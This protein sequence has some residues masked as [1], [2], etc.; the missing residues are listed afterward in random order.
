MNNSKSYMD[1]LRLLKTAVTIIGLTMMVVLAVVI[2]AQSNLRWNTSDLTYAFENG[3]EDIE[4]DGEQQGVSE[5][6][7]M[8][9]R[10][11]DLT[12]TQI[13]DIV[14]ADIVIKWD[15][16]DHEGKEL[17]GSGLAH[18]IFSQDRIMIACTV[19]MNTNKQW[20]IVP[21]EVTVGVSD[22]ATVAAHEIGH[23]LGLNHSSNPYTL[24]YK[25]LSR[26][27]RALHPEDRDVLL[28]L[29][30]LPTVCDSVTE[31]PERECLALLALYESAD[32][33]NWINNDGWLEDDTPCDWFR[34]QCRSGHVVI[35]SFDFRNPINGELP[36]EFA[37]LTALSHLTI[38]GESGLTSLSGIGQLT[39][40]KY[41]NVSDS[42]ITELP[43]EIGN[44]TNLTFLQVEHTQI[45]ALPDS[46]GQLS[47][48]RQL[49]VG[50][51]RLTELPDTL[52]SL[53]LLRTVR[54]S[55]NQLTQLPS[56]IDRWELHTLEVQNNR[57]L[58]DLPDAIKNIVS[59]KYLFYQ[60]TNLCIPYT[61]DFI[62]WYE[63]LQLAKGAGYCGT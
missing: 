48:L 7:A 14:D 33:D 30:P 8:W 26:V 55:D 36:P 61:T 9:S 29:Y 38:V 57:N 19:Y 63:G 34:V 54:A 28:E 11:S 5:A 20:T 6:F 46:L 16:K 39:S 53:T 45:A 32:G 44:L 25:T 15:N 37:D 1:H 35:L 40:L 41:L 3:T 17:K 12:F 62:S 52:D 60:N 4:G 42:P 49:Y 13:D 2:Q 10:E 22:V 47:N 27:W 31:I 51:N 18:R 58:S 24:M 43:D 59:L 56:Y 50:R 21:S 23:C